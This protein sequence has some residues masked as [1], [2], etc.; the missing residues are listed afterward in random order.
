M[1]RIAPL[2]KTAQRSLSL[3]D[4]AHLRTKAEQ[5]VAV[6]TGTFIWLCVG[7]YLLATG[8]G[9]TFLI[10]LLVAQYGANEHDAGLIISMATLS[11]VAFVILSGH[12]ADLMGTARAL[13]CAGMAVAISAL[14]F[15]FGGSPGWPMLLAGLVLGIGW[16]V[17]YTLAPILV[18][19]VIHPTR[20]TH[21]FAL[22]SGSMM[23]GIGTGPIAGRFFTGMGLPLESAFIFAAVACIIGAAIYAA[24]DPKLTRA[25]GAIRGNKINILTTIRVLRSKAI[26]P[27][28]MVGLG[29]AMFGALSSFQTS[30]AAERG[31]DYSLFFF[32]FVAAVIV[33]RL[34][35]SGKVVRREPHLTSFVLTSCIVAAIILLMIIETSALAYVAAAVLLGMGYGLTYSV[36]NGLVANEAPGEL[37]PQALLLF[38]LSYFI[39]VFGFPLF[40]GALIAEYGIQPMMLATLA[41]TVLNAAIPL[42]RLFRR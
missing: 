12:I 34:L 23:A 2:P 32:G 21:F 35:L 27:I 13:A 38:S 29:G 33:G 4:A 22:L 16:G 20:R 19:A 18:A 36:I 3:T 14:G 6:T 42:V 30:Y 28:V 8:Y 31:L 25:G 26:Y 37:I 17:F 7:G 39:G 1:R 15:A 9:V 10:P 11:T 41:I 40:A 5:S 24:L